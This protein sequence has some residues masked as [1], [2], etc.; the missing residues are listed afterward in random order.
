MRL[1]GLIPPHALAKRRRGDLRAAISK[2]EVGESFTV[3][4]TPKHVRM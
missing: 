4:I 1:S 3:T 2:A